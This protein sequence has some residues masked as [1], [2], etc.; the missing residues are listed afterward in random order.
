MKQ[1][2]AAKYDSIDIIFIRKHFPVMTWSE[3]LE[4]VNET[5]PA[6]KQ[7]GLSGLRFQCKRMGLSKGIQIRWSKQDVAFLVKNYK[8]IGNVEMA[9]L[10]N[11]RGKTYRKIAGKKVYRTF[12]KKHVEKKMKLLGLHRTPEEILKIKKRN[13]TTTNY[14]VITSDCNLWSLGKRKSYKEGDVRIWKGM[15]FVKIH[16][17]WTPYTRWFYHNFIAP[18]PKGHVVYHLDFDKLNDDPDNIACSS[19]KRISADMLKNGLDLLELREKKIMKELPLMN[20]DRQRAE[21]RQ[22]HTDLNR[23]RRLQREVKERL[24]NK[25]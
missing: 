15:R 14:R 17:G 19:R 7:V 10:L 11:K 21:I 18:V 5:R 3:L 4:A 9:S 8:E 16:G 1:K 25:Q 12:T 24:E 23:V 2:I 22:K 13:L 6:S 20:Y